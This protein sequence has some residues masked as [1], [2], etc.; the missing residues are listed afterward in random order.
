MPSRR[1]V[2]EEMSAVKNILIVGVGGQ[3]TLLAGKVLAK[4]ALAAGND[5][6]VSEVH[7]MAQRGGSVV[8]EVRFGPEVYSPLIPKGEGDVIVAF[9]Q[10]EALRWLPYLKPGGRV[11]VSDQKIEPMPVILGAAEYPEG[12]AERI[13]KT[14]P[15]TVAV[16]ALAIARECGNERAVNVVLL[17]VLA[18]ILN[19]PD[20][21][22]EYALGQSVPPA[23]LEANRAAFRAGREYGAET[24]S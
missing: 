8:T 22:W 19:L 12:I 6:K 2:I 9:E 23:T 15:G 10:L 14:C 17:G 7:G 18:G 13:Q 3:G 4:A 24:C 20:S 21:D 16:S 11:I 1:S 5:V